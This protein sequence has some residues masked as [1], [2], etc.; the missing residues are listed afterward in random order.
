MLT[1]RAD[2][3]PLHTIKANPPCPYEVFFV[4][5]ILISCKKMSRKYRQIKVSH[6]KKDKIFQGTAETPG[7]ALFHGFFISTDKGLAGIFQS[8]VVTH[9]VGLTAVSLYGIEAFRV[10]RL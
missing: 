2:T 9:I 1:N 8:V 3:N 7:S 10:I 6:G 4:D 5:A